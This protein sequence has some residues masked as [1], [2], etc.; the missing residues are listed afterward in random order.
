MKVNIIGAGLAGTSLAYILKKRGFEPVIYEASSSIAGGASG[1]KVGLYNPR[2][3]AQM[4]AVA[5][6]YS[7]AF[8]DVLKVFEEFDTAINWTPCGILALMD[9]ERKDIRFRKT[10]ASWGWSRDDMRIVSASEASEIAGVEIAYDALYTAKSGNISPNKLCHEYAKGVEVNLNHKVEDLAELKGD[11]T[12][13]ACG[14]GA[15]EFEEAKSLPIKAV[16]GQ[17][18]YIEASEVS[19]NLKVALSYSGY[20]APAKN[21]VHV[22]GATFQPWLNHSDLIPEDNLANLERLFEAVLSL[23]SRYNVVDS[24]AAVRCASRDHFPIVGQLGQGIY[25][26]LA[27]GSHGILTTLKSANILADMVGE[28]ENVASPELLSALCPDRFSA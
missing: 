5:G 20:I 21:G 18:S 10:A 16:R 24:N 1:N 15:L 23:E 4:D 14:M 25:C 12:I 9:N 7:D 3:S 19:S 6:F 2:F 28:C 13:L 22:L 17:V 26:S 11:I 27:H 8:F